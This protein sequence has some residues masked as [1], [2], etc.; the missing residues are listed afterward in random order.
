MG[1]ALD[2]E[3]APYEPFP[4]GTSRRRAF[5]GELFPKPA[6][7]LPLRRLVFLRGKGP[8]ARLDPA[9]AARELLGAL[10]PLGAS[11]WGRP[12][13]HAMRDL[14]RLVTAVPAVLLELGP[15]EAT[16]E[17]LARSLEE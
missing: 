3:Q 15:P 12:P 10:T 2:R 7:S 9:P 5:A 16:A 4:D 17:L 13:M 14:L 11:L 1:A 6:E 8:V